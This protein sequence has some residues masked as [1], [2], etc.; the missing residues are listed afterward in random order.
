MSPKC[1]HFTEHRDTQFTLIS[2]DLV[3]FQLLRGHANMDTHTDRQD[4]K[5]SAPTLRCQT[6]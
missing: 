4:L 2:D 1:Q 5:Y 6:G 3:I